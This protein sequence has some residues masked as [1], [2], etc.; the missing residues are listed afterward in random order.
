MKLAQ[1]L[2]HRADLQKRMK[3]LKQRINRNLLVQEGEKPV[4]Q[5]DN[6]IDAF[7]KI[8]YQWREIVRIINMVNNQPLEDSSNGATLSEMVV[9]RDHL[10]MLYNMASE[11]HSGLSP[12]MDRFSRSEIKQIP[13]IEAD[14]IR[15]SCDEYA[16][17]L[18]KL[19]DDIQELNWSTEVPDTLVELI[20]KTGF[21]I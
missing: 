5:P 2:N 7:I 12:R 6:L 4:E 16:G 15:K 8:S 19:D 21:D 1:L 17:K 3:D 13:S 14:K 18:R 11:T 10:R 9:M 20:K